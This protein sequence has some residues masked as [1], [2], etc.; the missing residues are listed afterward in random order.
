MPSLPTSIP[1]DL[2]CN[3][4]VRRHLRR[5]RRPPAAPSSREGLFQQKI[6]GSASKNRKNFRERNWGILRRTGCRGI[7]GRSRTANALLVRCRIGAGRVEACTS[8]AASDRLPVFSPGSPGNCGAGEDQ[9]WDL[10]WGRLWYDPFRE[11]LFQRA[12]L[13]RC[14]R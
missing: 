3:G 1:Q 14:C 4:K 9:I 8:T 7:R 11:K 2:F 5:L 10:Y 6:C 13:G 12:G